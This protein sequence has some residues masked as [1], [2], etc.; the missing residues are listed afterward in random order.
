MTPRPTP[1]PSAHSG[2]HPRNLHRVPY[3]FSRLR[4]AWPALT[5]YVRDNGFGVDSVDFAQPAAV[6]A[7][8]QALLREFYGIIEW[9][10]PPGYLCPPIPGRADYIHHLADLLDEGGAGG[11]PRGDSVGILDVGVGASCVYPI[12]GRHEY[13]WRFIGTETDPLALANARRIIAANPALA[14]GV[15]VRRQTDPLTL[16]RGVVE[17]GEHFAAVLCNPPFHGSAAEAGAGSRRKVR[18]LHG[19][20]SLAPV[21]NFGGQ[22]HELWC[23]GGEV[24]FVR[25]MIAESAE[26]A[27]QCR[28]F[29]TLVSKS[30]SLPSLLA[31]LNQ[32]PV[33]AVKII[34][35]AQG[36]KQSRIVAW[37]F[38]IR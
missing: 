6:K 24:G 38:A 13:G 9:D 26:F 11:I 31:A 19:D 37:T 10:L 23:Q 17:P 16:F 14:D 28:W 20:R 22:P 4:R 2:L 25:R 32:V 36:R 27:G 21:L 35:M 8:N 33:R 34:P 18:H 1:S 15:R 30:A 12:L 3:D 7:L 5:P 29:T